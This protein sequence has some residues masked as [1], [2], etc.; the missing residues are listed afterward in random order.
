MRGGAVSMQ[1]PW[2]LPVDPSV[3]ADNVKSVSFP[4]LKECPC[5]RSSVRLQ[6]HG[7]YPRYAVVWRVDYLIRICRY[8]CP[9][10]KR[11][12]SLLPLFLFSHFQHDKNSILASLRDF[13]SGK[14]P[15][16]IFSR[17]L[18]SFWRR[19]FLA[20]IPAIVSALRE[21]GWQDALPGGE[22]AK[23]IK[24]AERLSLSP[25]DTTSKVNLNNR[26]L[27]NFMALSF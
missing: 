26:I 22:Q 23:A 14:K 12:V 20:N 16:G 15:P 25:S 8:L 7:F 4:V 13:F 11:T 9:S 21:R 6:R 5:C 19:R 2:L 10:C 17:Q 24:I 27:A 3:Y 18:V 1:I